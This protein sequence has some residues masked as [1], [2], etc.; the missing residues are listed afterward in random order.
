MRILMDM[1]RLQTREGTTI[2][3]GAVVDDIIGVVLLSVV[4]MMA[5]PGGELD[6]GQALQIGTIGFAVWFALLLI[7]AGFHKY[8][9]TYLLQTGSEVNLKE[10]DA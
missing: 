5:K 1:R 7:G 4:V 9:S 2:L 10:E 3:V 6:I 8:I